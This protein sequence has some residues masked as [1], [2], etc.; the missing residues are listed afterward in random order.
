M[1]LLRRDKGPNLGHMV[2]YYTGSDEVW[3]SMFVFPDAVK[4]G[5]TALLA[6]GMTIYDYMYKID[7]REY[8]RVKVT[9]ENLVQEVGS[10]QN[11]CQL[12]HDYDRAITWS[13]SV[14]SQAFSPCTLGVGVYGS[15]TSGEERVSF[16]LAYLNFLVLGDPGA[17][18]RVERKGATNVFKYG[19]KS[20]LSP[21]LTA[22]RSPMM[23]LPGCEHVNG[24][25]FDFPDVIERAKKF[26]AK[27]GIPDNR[28]TFTMG[29][30]LKDVPQ[31][32]EVDTISHCQKLA[33]NFYRG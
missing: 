28:I 32:T 4:N 7:T 16:C 31:S 14:C 11:R 12:A 23:K 8:D 19:R 33:C 15:W 20:A 18:S 26:L 24:V 27:E 30:I 6:H 2:A 22:P 5:D 21:V 3:S 17:V 13:C 10:R 29:N 9:T 25:L 1:E